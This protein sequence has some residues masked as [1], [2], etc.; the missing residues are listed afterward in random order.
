MYDLESDVIIVGCGPAG[1]FTALEL[2]KR[3]DLSI[4][5]IDR[6]PDLEKRRCPSRIGYECANCSPCAMLCGW[7]G[8]G[9]FSD[10][11]LTLSADVGGW[12][13]EYIGRD[14]LIKLVD[15]VDKMYLAF[16][17]PTT[18]FGADMDVIE[19]LQ[20]RAQLA[21]LK[22][23][24]MK[25]R[26]LGTEKCFEVIKAMRDYLSQRVKILTEKTVQKILIDGSQVTGVKLADGTKIHA[27]YVVLAPG[28]SGAEWLK[29]LSSEL[30]FK[31]YNNPVD[32][33]V[34]VEVPASVMEPLT[35]YLYEPKLLYYSKSFDDKIRTFCFNPYGE[36]ITESYDGVVTVNGHSFLNKKTGNTNFA[37]LVS[38]SFTEPFKEPIAYGKYIARLANLLSGGIIVQRLGDLEEGRRSTQERIKRNIVEP[39]LKSATPGDLSFVLPYRYLTNILEMLQAMDKIT[40][41]VYSRYTLL[42][43]VEVKFYSLRLELSKNLETKIENLY[44]AGDGAGITR[45]LIQASS[46][47]VV[48]ARSILQRE[49]IPVPELNDESLPMKFPSKS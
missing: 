35:K 1:I 47:G 36:V 32:I 31:T 48:V 29:E 46:S 5:M 43:G 37:V 17:A 28:R 8:A 44:A 13:E 49:N 14:E 33:G 42:Y 3:S 11:K 9:I 27:K 23:I 45:G 34:R 22:L 16:G 41:G 7:G 25:V 26:H 12:L 30:N 6:G 39:T 4:I 40:P 10:G 20:R 21:G 18:L 19:R 38:T 24:P 15:Y 2:A